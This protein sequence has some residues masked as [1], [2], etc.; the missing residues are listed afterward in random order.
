M[1]DSDKFSADDDLGRIELVLKDLMKDEHSNGRM[2]DRSDSFKALEA[3]KGMPGTLDWSVGYFSKARLQESQMKQQCKDKHVENVEQLKQQVYQRAERKLRET[4]KNESAEMQQLKDDDWENEQRNIISSSVPP[5]EFPSGILSIQVHQIVGLSVENTRKNKSPEEEDED[6]ENNDEDQLP[7]SYCT[8]ILNDQKIFRT[9][10]KPKNSAPF[11]NACTERFIRDW[12][13]AIVLISVRDQRVHEDNALLGHVYLNI[14]DLFQKHKSSCINSFWPIAGGIGY[15]RLRVSVVFRSTSLDLPRRELGWDT[16][17]VEVA[18]EAFAT[19]GTS[20]DVRGHRVKVRTNTSK[21]QM[22]SVKLQNATTDVDATCAKWATSKHRSLLLAVRKRYASNLVLEFRAS[23]SGL[24]PK[25][26]RCVAFSIA[27][28]KDVVDEE[29]TELN[30]PIY[31]DRDELLKRAVANVLPQSELSA[32]KIGELR[33]RLKLWR[34]LGRA[35]N[36]LAK[37]NTDVS[38][39]LEVRDSAHELGS[40]P[41]IVG[42]KG[43][44]QERGLN[45]SWDGAGQDEGDDSDSDSSDDD[46]QSHS[47]AEQ[48]TTQGDDDDSDRMNKIGQLAQHA[49]RKIPFTKAHQEAKSGEREEAE[50]A[51]GIRQPESEST[52]KSNFSTGESASH[53]GQSE[54]ITG[55]LNSDKVEFNELD[56][57]TSQQAPSAPHASV[58][59]VDG[60]SAVRDS[61]QSPDSPFQPDQNK[62]EVQG[63]GAAIDRQAESGESGFDELD[64]KTSQQAS[65]A[66]QASVG[67]ERGPDGVNRELHSST[68][69]GDGPKKELDQ[70]EDAAQDQVGREDYGHEISTPRISTS[71][72]ANYSIFPKDNPYA[73]G[74]PTHSRPTTATTSASNECASTPT[75][76]SHTPSA[77][78]PNASFP[79]QRDSATPSPDS[80]V[81]RRS[82]VL[83]SIK[84][85][86]SLRNSPLSKSEAKKDKRAS[87][88]FSDNTGSSSN[89][90]SSGSRPTSTFYDRSPLSSHPTASSSGTA[91]DADGS[92]TKS[93]TNDS[94][95]SMTPSSSHAYDDAAQVGNDGEGGGSDINGN[96]KDDASNSTREQ[97]HRR[98]RGIMQFK[99]P[100]TANWVKHKAE[101]AMG[102]IQR[103]LKHEEREKTGGVETEV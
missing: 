28:L 18:P 11:F 58:G 1:W 23:S 78:T 103:G 56:T 25:S 43:W 98:H 41:A 77:N 97:L 48:D 100:R 86:F 44:R 32:S 30:L 19:K 76:S 93:R 82:G 39:I 2:W 65:S 102:E 37:R 62:T 34:G 95:T 85:S 31:T 35:H 5:E 90:R 66:P 47:G 73:P 46:D 88:V 91:T 10:T 45:S 80:S 87:R 94:R 38:D 3:G 52:K 89:V 15:G 24:L 72:K 42:A 53:P 29:W 99:G 4:A 7:S 64:T 8:V 69:A 71:Q 79:S 67:P 84:R 92:P 22:R 51:A 27:W 61:L 57:K 20:K 36:S 21:G 81:K 59:P 40:G 101:N 12:Q 75:R 74:T 55:T 96:D 49:R 70:D 33:I 68:T 60:A 83:G 63:G 9:R 26:K 16:G 50:A 13:N 6:G 17:V 14:G 54:S